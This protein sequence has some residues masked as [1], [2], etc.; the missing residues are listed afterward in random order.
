MIESFSDVVS[1]MQYHLVHKDDGYSFPFLPKYNK[2]VGNI[3]PGQYTVVSGMAASGKTSFVDQNYVLNVLLHRDLCAEKPPMKIF[4]FTLKDTALKKFQSLL[5]TYMKV[6]HNLRMDIPTLNSQPGRI[7]NIDEEP[8]ILTAIDDAEIFFNDLISDGTLQ[9]IDS[10]NKPS[11]IHSTVSEYLHDLDED[12]ERPFVMVVVDSTEHLGIEND[13]YH[14][15]QGSELDFKFDT[16]MRTLVK[17]HNVHAVIITPAHGANSRFPKE[18]EP[19]FRQLG[20]YGKNC[21]KGVI[22]YNPVGENNTTYLK[23]AIDPDMYLSPNGLNMLRFWHVVRNVDGVDSANERLLFLP[24]SGF[25][26][27]C[28]PSCPIYGFDDVKTK[29]FNVSKDPFFKDTSSTPV[30]PEPEPPEDEE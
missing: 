1:K 27:E 19:N 16:S 11:A 25:V 17:E 10:I 20:V 9:V 7:Y 23:G 12:I 4:Y 26:V 6:V 24:G 30:D 21:D 18:N 8:A 29:V 2:T 28:E 13:G 5:C 3:L 22:L 15:V 14:L